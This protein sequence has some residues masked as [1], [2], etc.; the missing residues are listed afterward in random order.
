MLDKNNLVQFNVNH[1]VWV[2]LTQKGVETLLKHRNRYLD[3]MPE[4]HNMELVT[5]DDINKWY[6]V[7]KDGY[8]R[9]QMHQFMEA[10]GGTLATTNLFETNVYF[11]LGELLWPTPSEQIQPEVQPEQE[12]YITAEIPRCEQ[13]GGSI[14]WWAPEDAPK[15]IKELERKN[16]DYDFHQFV[17]KPG[18]GG[19]REYAIMKLKNK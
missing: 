10:F 18:N 7:T 16:P 6:C 19:Y 17:T 5:M 3:F 8:Y 9:F 15:V 12:K 1:Y 14:A 13:H 11:N 2:K 4:V